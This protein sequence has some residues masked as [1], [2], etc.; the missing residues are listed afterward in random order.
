MEAEN[1]PDYGRKG[2]PN[3]QNGGEKVKTS[4]T[5]FL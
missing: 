3:H 5:P 2:I 4:L 1:Y